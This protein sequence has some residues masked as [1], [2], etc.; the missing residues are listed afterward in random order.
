MTSLNIQEPAVINGP[1]AANAKKV[2]FPNLDGLRFICFLLVFLFHSYKVLFANLKGT[3]VYDIVEFLFQHGELGVNFFFVLS[4]FLI[5]FL[6][7]RE[8]EVSGTVHIKNFYIR[9]VLRIWPLFYLCVFIGFVV[10]PLAKHFAG[11]A[12][13]ETSDPWYYV[14]LVN[15]FDYI[16]Q[17]SISEQLFPDALILIVLWSVAVEE[18]FYLVWPVILKYIPKRGYPL[19]F[20]AIILFTLVF[21]FFHV[22]DR[23]GDLHDIAVLRFHTFA[24]IGDMAVGA[25]MAYYCSY[26]SRFLVWVT[27]LKK[28]QLLFIYLMSVAVLLFR[29]QLFGHFAV[30]TILERVVIAILF[31]L[32]ILEQNFCKNSF[33][34]FSSFKNM[35]KLGMYTYGLYCLHFLVISILGSVAQKL[36]FLLDNPVTAIVITLLALFFS[37]ILCILSYRFYEKPFLKLK[38]KFAFITK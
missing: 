35:S 11:A 37:I 14:F 34:K 3:V 10:W 36:G 1:L 4:G 22:G 26:Q 6:L 23:G 27:N 8:V 32:I 16:H 20:L 25:L 33:F 15:N 5:T 9:R 12:S 29:E 24:V 18:Q 19:I 38:D 31:G 28:S 21:R 7:I 13:V 30:A 2:F 17:Q